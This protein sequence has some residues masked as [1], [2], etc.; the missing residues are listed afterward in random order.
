MSDDRTNDPEQTI[1]DCNQSLARQSMGSRV[2]LLDL[3]AY[4]I[5]VRRH[6]DQ[7][8][9]RGTIAEMDAL[10]GDL[11]EPGQDKRLRSQERDG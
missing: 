10:V 1:K 6:R 7:D 2:T 4:A 8:V 5:E 9:L 11:E 3:R